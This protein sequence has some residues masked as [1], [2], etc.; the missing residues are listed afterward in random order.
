MSTLVKS[1]GTS[2]LKSMMEDFWNA[3]KFFNKPFFNPEKL[4]AVNVRET[5]NR[6]ELELA[7]PGFK[8]D[9]FQV[10]TENGFLTISA[11]IKEEKN[12]EKEN[13]TRKE[14]SYSSFSRTFNLPEDVVEDDVNASYHNG[15]L[16]VELK[17]SGK[18]LT[19][20]KEVK[21]S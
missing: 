14:F 19:S 3:D 20:K 15:I 21:I 8:K 13:F 17:K 16:S 2:S 9:D 7:V 5:K 6:Y 18:Q 1:N 12:E 4:P 11:E 10:T